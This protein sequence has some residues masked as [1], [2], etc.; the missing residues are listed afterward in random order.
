MAGF[1]SVG[2]FFGVLAGVGSMPVRCEMV[3]AP[4]LPILSI[5]REA[6]ATA[7]DS[8]VR[9][10]GPCSGSMA[11]L[12]RCFFWGVENGETMPVAA[13]VAGRR[14]VFLVARKEMRSLRELR[15]DGVRFAACWEEI[16]ADL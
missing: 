10:C 4:D 16:R 12:E 9:R 6:A 11:E 8:A 15:G 1:F 3:V 13:V 2:G 14:C 5:P 7:L